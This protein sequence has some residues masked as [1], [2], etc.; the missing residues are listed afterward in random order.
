MQ[1]G[2]IGL[3][4]M[5][6]NMVRRLLKGGHD[7][8]VYAPELA[9][10]QDLAAAGAAGSASLAELVESLAAPRVVW[11][12]IPAGA[13]DGVIA[14]LTPLLE[15]GD[16]IVDG[17]NSHYVD[18][19]RRARDLGAAGLH[20]VD[21][22]VSGGIRGLE[23]GYCQMIGGE[24]AVYERLEPLF[25]T[26]APAGI[27]SGVSL[28]GAHPGSTAE[29][30]RPKAHA[31]AAAGY[32]YCGASGAGHFVKMVHNG[33]EYGL[34]A[35]YAEGLN[36]LR[37]ADVGLAGRK[38]DAETS[39]LKSPEHFAYELDLAAIAEVWRHGSVIRSW[40]LDLI[41]V[42][43]ARDPELA[44]FDTNVPDSGEGRWTVQA[45]IEAGVPTPVLATALL[46]RFTSRGADD[47]ANRAL[48]ALRFE[49][50]GH[51]APQG[52]S[53]RKDG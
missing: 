24:S 34:M 39:P 25:A 46:A 8:A 4:R 42:A 38:V 30:V 11:I 16:T 15:T 9:A 29:A 33:I 52:A 51:G 35:A 50:G 7:C 27:R 31:T 18:D 13:V 2:M 47:F 21:V 3:G 22:G 40:L 26:L 14:Q 23:N 53:A 19:I 20:Y 37:N 5:G 6:G 36:L 10:V 44:C 48:S 43:L 45:A 49:F 12:M 32:L 41:G 28:P 1:L 17:G